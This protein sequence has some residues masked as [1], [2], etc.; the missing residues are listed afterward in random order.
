MLNVEAAQLEKGV[1]AGVLGGS[2]DWYLLTWRSC[3][4]LAGVSGLDTSGCIKQAGRLLDIQYI[5]HCQLQ[6]YSHSSVSVDM[7]Q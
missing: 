6:S 5:S 4:C 2:S 3:Q 7:S 1:M